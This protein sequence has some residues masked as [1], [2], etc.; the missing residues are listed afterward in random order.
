VLRTG[1]PCVERFQVFPRRGT[2]SKLPS[3]SFPLLEGTREIRGPNRHGL[4]PCRTEVHF[5]ATVYFL[6]PDVVFEVPKDKVSP[7]FPI[8][9]GKQIEIEGGGHSGR[10][11]VR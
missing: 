6:I 4:P 7:E 2:C 8:D 10:V 11:I 5:D 3:R 9:P 1:I